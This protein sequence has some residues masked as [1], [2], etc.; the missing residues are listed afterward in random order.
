[1]RS[2]TLTCFVALAAF[3]LACS[4]PTPPQTPSETDGVSSADAPVASEA[5]PSPP[6]PTPT[7]PTTPVAGGKACKTSAECERGQ[8]CA[9]DEGCDKTWTCQ[10]SPPCTKDY[11]PYCGCDGQTFRAS[12]SCPGAKY[13]KRGGC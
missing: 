10:P 9:G 2:A 1:M 13:Q 4:S 3:T 12:G 6:T 11:V 5:P 7:T 8:V